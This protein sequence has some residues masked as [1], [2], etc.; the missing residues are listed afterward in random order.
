MGLSPVSCKFIAYASL[1]IDSCSLR[2]LFAPAEVSAM[3][4]REQ[5]ARREC[6]ADSC[7]RMGYF[8]GYCWRHFKEHGA[9]A[10]VSALVARKLECEECRADSCSRKIR[11]RGYCRRHFKEHGDPAEVSAVVAREQ[12]ARW[13]CRADSCSRMSRLRGYCWRHF[14]VHGARVL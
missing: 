13:E 11:F 1:H 2:I 9:P 7:S 6:R 14:K 10:E 5:K 8:R 12:K 3:V 4:A